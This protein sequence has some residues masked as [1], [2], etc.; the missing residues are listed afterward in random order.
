MYFLNGSGMLPAECDKQFLDIAA[1]LDR[2]G[3]DF[4][5]IIVSTLT[6]TSTY[7]H[8]VTILCSTTGQYWDTASTGCV[9]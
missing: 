7:I 8:I 5:Q 3:M 6:L 2:Y 9:L 4:H 1:R